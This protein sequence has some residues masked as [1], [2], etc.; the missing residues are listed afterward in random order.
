M[1]TDAY[2][3]ATLPCHRHCIA[4]FMH[5]TCSLHKSKNA[6]CEDYRRKPT[7]AWSHSP[8][9]TLLHEAQYTQLS[10]LSIQDSPPL[11]KG[12]VQPPEQCH[13]FPL[14]TRDACLEVCEPRLQWCLGHARQPHEGYEPQPEHRRTLIQTANASSTV[15]N[16]SAI[17]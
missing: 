6:Q 4:A 7:G 17:S 9:L 5:C 3:T 14:R 16:A 8:C 1:R 11:L 15:R 10:V 12:H 2:H 13:H